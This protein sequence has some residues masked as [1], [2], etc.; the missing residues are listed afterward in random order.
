MGR[1]FSVC[2]VYVNVCLLETLLPSG[3]LVLCSVMS[4]PGVE[5]EEMLDIFILFLRYSGEAIPSTCSF[6][7]S[8]GRPEYLKYELVMIRNEMR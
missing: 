7:P 6:N 8:S 1:S 4:V 5:V 3:F 2:I